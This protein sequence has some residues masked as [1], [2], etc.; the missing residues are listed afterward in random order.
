MRGSLITPIGRKIRGN[1]S[2]GRVPVG[3]RLRRPHRHS[4]EDSPSCIREERPRGGPISPASL[5]GVR[6]R[7]RQNFNHWISFP[8]G[9]GNSPTGH[10][11][12]LDRFPIA[13]AVRGDSVAFPGARLAPRMR[14]RRMP[15]G[16]TR[17]N[18]RGA[19]GSRTR[20]LFHRRL[21]SDP[22][23]LLC[24]PGVSSVQG[25]RTRRKGA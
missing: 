17:R 13:G 3:W 7:I 4:S 20:I 21:V 14:C 15:R 11:M 9:G 5:H 10:R 6:V 18:P 12:R 25:A 2:L 24:I 23:G 8:D 16:G 1:N 22:E 19:R